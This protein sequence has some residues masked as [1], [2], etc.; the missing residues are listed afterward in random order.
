MA[1]LK[2]SGL[3][4]Q[5]KKCVVERSQLPVDHRYPGG[6]RGKYSV[7]G[8]RKAFEEHSLEGMNMRPRDCYTDHMVGH[9]RCVF[10][11]YIWL[12]KLSNTTSLWWIDVYYLVFNY[13]F[14]R[15][16]PSSG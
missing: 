8:I 12:N 9:P 15:L 2:C 16:W 6:W 3:I 5:G 4:D 1:A 7:S 10:I 14:R 11:N 13:M